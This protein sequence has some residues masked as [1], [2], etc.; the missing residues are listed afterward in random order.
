VLPEQVTQAIE[1]T[2]FAAACASVGQLGD[3]AHRSLCSGAATD[4]HRGDK[5]AVQIGGSRAGCRW[6][7]GYVALW[8]PC[9]GTSGRSGDSLVGLPGVPGTVRRGGQYARPE[10]GGF[11]AHIHGAAFD[12]GVRLRVRLEVEVP[13]RLAGQTAVGR[14]DDQVPAVGEELQQHAVREAGGLV[15]GLTAL[16]RVASGPCQTVPSLPEANAIRRAAHRSPR[17]HGWQQAYEGEQ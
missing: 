14:G 4:G 3:R 9:G 7:R 1:L 12:F 17:S 16:R 11:C 8:L 13:V 15:T 10:R 5:D 6:W 2:P